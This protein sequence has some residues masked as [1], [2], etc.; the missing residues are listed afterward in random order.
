MGCVFLE[1]LKR[2]NRQIRG[3]EREREFGGPKVQVSVCDRCLK[4]GVNQ[5]FQNSNI[6]NRKRRS[7]KVLTAKLRPQQTKFTNDRFSS[8]V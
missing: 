7:S 5:T 1:S 6:E 2:T 4:K 8:L 3:G